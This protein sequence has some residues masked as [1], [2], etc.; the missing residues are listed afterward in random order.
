MARYKLTIECEFDENYPL[1]VHSSAVQSLVNNCCPY[2]FRIDAKN[3]YCKE[4]SCRDCWFKAL[5]E[6]VKGYVAE[7][8]HVER[9]G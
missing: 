1:S 7:N 6:G 4:T 3:T 9:L 2:D 8:V 5:S